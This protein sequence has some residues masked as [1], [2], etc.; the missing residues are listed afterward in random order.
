MYHDNGCQSVTSKMKGG[1]YVSNKRALVILGLFVVIVVCVGLMAG[2]IEDSTP[3]SDNG[4]VTSTAIPTEATKGPWNNP[5]LPKNILPVHYD[6]WLH[7]DFYFDGTTYTGR[8]N[9]TIDIK[10]NTNYLIVHMK[11]MNITKTQVFEG[12]RVLDIKDPFEYVDNQF[13]VVE[14]VAAM[15]AGLTVVLHLQFASSLVNGIV[16][17]YKSTYINANT[18]I[19]R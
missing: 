12:D 8:V 1:F 5:F 14:T 18:G 17:F 16:G 3:S 13:W 7:P 10:E 15:P 2:L 6:L 11:M 19:Q 9:I 4:D